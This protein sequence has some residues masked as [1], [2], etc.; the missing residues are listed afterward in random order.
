MDYEIGLETVE[1]LVNTEIKPSSGM[2][3]NHTDESFGYGNEIFRFE[4]AL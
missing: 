1:E 2:N 3:V 4:F